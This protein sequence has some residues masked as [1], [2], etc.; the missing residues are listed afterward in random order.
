MTSRQP[1]PQLVLEFLKNDANED[2]GLGNAGIETYR[3]EPYAGTAREVDKTAVTPPSACPFVSFD[4]ID[5]PFDQFPQIDRLKSSIAA[6]LRKARVA[7]DEKEI[8]FFEQATTVLESG[9]LKVLRISDSN[10]TGLLGPDETGTPFH[11]LVKGS[12]V[13]I[14]MSDASGGSF[15]IGKNAVYAISDLQTVFYSTAYVDD[16]G[17][18]HFLAQGKSILVSHVDDDGQRRRAFG[19]WGLPDFKPVDDQNAVPAWLRRSEQGTSVFAVGFRDTPD[20]QH[21]IAYSLLQNFFYAIHN[22]EM[23]FS[24]DNGR[25]VISKLG[26]NSLFEDDA[27]RQAAANNDRL[28]QYE[29]SEE[30]VPL[31]HLP[32]SA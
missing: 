14:K 32:R 30:S 26:L 19:Y 18:K 1:S 25:I 5:V 22:G 17:Q 15:G 24:I 3:E 27:I 23:E 11:S 29:L 20:W 13:S 6:C 31:P 10:T 12:G 9:P 21:R 2:E 4:V 7:S 28:P 8:A 16:A